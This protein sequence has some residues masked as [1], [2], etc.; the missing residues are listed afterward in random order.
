ML[1]STTI[2]TALVALAGAFGG[3]YLNN[4]FTDKRWEKQISHER[5]K[6]ERILLRSKGEETFKL[7]KKW[8]KELFIFHSSRIAFLQKNIQK[9]EMEKNIDGTVNVS[10][11]GELSVLI[12]LYF[13]EL[14]KDLEAI[15]KQVSKVNQIYF[16]G[17]NK[18]WAYAASQ[19]MANECI[20]Y[21]RLLEHFLRELKSKIKSI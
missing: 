18:I 13:S 8:E 4:R 3:A 12:D 15:H 2:F 5:E 10:T 19:E 16:K 21:E 1:T 11:H 14:S 20:V 7:L 9:N 17:E 6:E